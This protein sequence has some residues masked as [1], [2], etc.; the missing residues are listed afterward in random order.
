MFLAEDMV[1]SSVSDVVV[2]VWDAGARAR[3]KH[4]DG[5]D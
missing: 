2:A 5:A 1:C 3:E 4:A